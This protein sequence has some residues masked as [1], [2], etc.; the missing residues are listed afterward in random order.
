MVAKIEFHEIDSWGLVE[1]TSEMYATVTVFNKHG[2]ILRERL[3]TLNWL[4]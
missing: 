4:N 1:S 3:E 2:Q